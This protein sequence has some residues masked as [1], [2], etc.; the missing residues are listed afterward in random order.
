MPK[1]KGV[2]KKKNVVVTGGA[3]FIGSNICDIL[4]KDKDSR[5]ICIDNLITG[6]VINIDQL[7]QSEDFKFIRHDI[8]QPLDLLK[9]PELAHYEI[10]IEGIQEVYNCATPT[11]YKEAKKFS[12]QTALTNSL[13]IKNS[14]DLA[15]QYSAKMVHLSSSAIYG[16]PLPEDNHFSEDYWG[17]I[18]PVDERASYNESKRFSETLCK[19]Y[20]D[21]HG[22]Q[23]TIARVFATYGPRMIMD[24]GRHVPDF[25]SAAIDNKDIIIYGDKDVTTSFCYITDMVD[26][27]MKLVQSNNLG[28]FN[29]GVDEEYKLSEVAQKVVDLVGSKSKI[30]F[31]KPLQG[32]HVKGLPNIKKIKEEVGWF[33]LTKLDEGLKETIE[34]MRSVKSHFQQQGIW[35]QS[36]LDRKE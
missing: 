23:T 33:P 20:Y 26:G 31:K 2:F 10:E 1:I 32:M 12:E 6:T 35:D 30:T 8:T 9:F 24:E 14:L 18:N 15:K 25:I 4:A 7:L 3:G 19:T 22:V 21:V 5:V 11:S 34:Y 13:G 16:D 29:I 28:P 36:T 27:L 17:F